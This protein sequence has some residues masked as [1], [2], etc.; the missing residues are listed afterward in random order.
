MLLLLSACTAGAP[1]PSPVDA[2]EVLRAAMDQLPFPQR[3]GCVRLELGEVALE[4]DRASLREDRSWLRRWRDRMLNR[5]RLPERSWSPEVERT[6][7]DRARLP[8]KEK[9]AL[10]AAETRILERAQPRLIAR[11]SAAD[12]PKPFTPEAPGG[13]CQWGTS[14]SSPA[15]AGDLAFVEIGQS[16]GNLCG[17]G[18]LLALRREAEGWRLVA[19]A[20]TWVS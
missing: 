3:G 9:R 14:F 20:P 1:S 8:E 16:C 4:W 5:A 10:A 6:S 19:S 15:F 7:G 2:R 11:L 18:R 12:V 17:S 13:G